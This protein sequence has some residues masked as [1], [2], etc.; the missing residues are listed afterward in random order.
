MS[1]I[2]Y[3]STTDPRAFLPAGF[4]LSQDVNQRA[5]A[6]PFGGSEQ[7]VDMLNDRWRISM[8]L[9]PC[10]QAEAAKREAFL[11]ALRG[12][13]NHT[14][15][16][17]FGRPVPLGTL[18]SSQGLI[19]DAAQGADS[20][21]IATTA[22]ATLLAGDMLGVDGLLLQ[23]RA[24]C[25][26]NADGVLVVPLVNRL[27]RAITGLRRASTATYVDG[28]GV[29]QTAAVDV[30]RLA[31]SGLLLEPAAMNLLLRS[32]E[33]NSAPWGLVAAT[34]TANAIAAPDGTITAEKLIETAATS[35]HY[36]AQSVSLTEGQQ[37]AYSQH[38][39]AGE[40][41]H[42]L[43]TAN[44]S[45]TLHS[46]AINLANGAVASATGSPQN[47]A[48]QSLQ[49][50]W[51]RV[52]FAFTA[53]AT[54]SIGLEVRLSLDGI[55]ANRSY[56]GDGSSGAYVWG[57]Q[58]ETGTAASSYIPTAASAATRAADILTPVVWD[59]PSAPFRLVG[60]PALRYVPGYSEGLSLDFVE[61][62][63]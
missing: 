38:V 26:A 41:G 8:E 44:G 14:E 37:Y 16:H 25:T 40:R 12:Q 55:W 21:T 51:W 48:A 31:E 29:L 52:S 30:V 42:L 11:A 35:N 15:L 53:G 50:G 28:S 59:R 18:A 13:V 3:P 27:R 32:S 24:D 17:H 6:S 54:A 10:N 23:C 33:L 56:A 7:A 34:I 47:I 57:A 22:G 5:F 1:L 2:T 46:V 61:K 45:A 19:Y 9:P 39:K 58:L 20:I 4:S 36:V 49:D 63:D 62:V 60:R 43:I